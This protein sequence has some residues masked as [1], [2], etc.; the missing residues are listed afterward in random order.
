MVRFQGNDAEVTRG[1]TF[2]FVVNYGTELPEGTVARFAVKRKLTDLKCVF[3]QDVEVPADGRAVFAMD[4]EETWKLKPMT[5]VYDVR[6]IIPHEGEADEVRNPMM[7]GALHV[8]PAVA[9]LNERG[10]EDGE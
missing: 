9:G 6:L 5:Y 3:E 7:P 8:L 4:T 2:V 1:E 10:E